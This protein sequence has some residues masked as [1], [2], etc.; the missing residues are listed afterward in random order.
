MSPSSETQVRCPLTG[1][2]YRWAIPGGPSG[3][4]LAPSAVFFLNGIGLDLEGFW[5]AIEGLEP[6]PPN[7]LYR[8][9]YHIALTVPGFENEE[10]RIP[11]PALS[12]A[13][14]AGRVAAFMEHFVAEHPV[15]EVVLYGFSFGSDLAVEVLSRLG[16][17]IPLVRLILAELNVHANSCFITSRIKAAFDAARGQ[18]AS[19]N[20][21][22]YNGFVSR[23]VRAS[24]AGHLGES[25][26]EDMALYFRVI[27]RKDWTQLARSAAEA[28]EDPE[29]RV[30][31]FL[32]NTS[33]RPDTCFDLVFSDSQ[34][35]RILKRRLETWG[36]NLGRI[37]VFDSTAHAHFHHMS[38][39]GLL[40]NLGGWLPEVL[41][42]PL[43]L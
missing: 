33:E 39:A 21:E 26:M 41:S 29:A 43:C 15:Q 17:A 1:V 3:G 18:G 24:A 6:L 14:Q 23:V 4:A 37:R 9:G 5:K 27:A 19:R 8:H 16:A 22:A 20:R 13:E 34:D 42:S 25:L 38:R 35:L 31:R 36:G 7:Y 12:M 2:Q 40:E 32:G 28:S 30:A 10:D 11:G